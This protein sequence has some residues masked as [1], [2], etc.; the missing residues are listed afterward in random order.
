VH[1]YK[2]DR[3]FDRNTVLAVDVLMRQIFT[4]LIGVTPA[5]AGKV[6]ASI[7]KTSAD[8][9]HTDRHHC[10][11][12]QAPGHDGDAAPDRFFT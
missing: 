3:Y 2:H 10:T 6:T 11:E 8:R 5:L 12:R 7:N 9:R 1:Y 4:R